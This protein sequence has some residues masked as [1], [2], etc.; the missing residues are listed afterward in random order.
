M[1]DVHPTETAG[2]GIAIPKSTY[3]KPGDPKEKRIECG[4]CGFRFN[5]DNR[6]EGNTGG[7]GQTAGVQIKDTVHTFAN[8]E[9]NLPIGLR[10]ISTFTAASRTVKD[11]AVLSGLGCSLCGSTNPRAIGRTPDVLAQ[12]INLENQ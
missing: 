4:Q 9:A 7:D 3:R 5:P 2:L 6:A 11:P 1:S 12:N 8:T 10:N